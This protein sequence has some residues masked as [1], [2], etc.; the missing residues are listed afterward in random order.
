MIGRAQRDG[1][2]ALS[3]DTGTV[4]K[5]DIA[6]WKNINPNAGDIFY[7]LLD[8]G[9]LHGRSWNITN[10]NGDSIYLHPSS[11]Y[12]NDFKLNHDGHP[13]IYDR[14]DSVFDVFD[15]SYG[16][17][18]K[19][20]TQDHVTD[21]HELQLFTDHYYLIGYDP[22]VI[23]MKQYNPNYSSNAFVLGTV[24]QEFDSG[25]HLI[26]DWDSFDHVEVIEA[27]HEQ[28]GAQYIDY[29]HTNSIEEDTDGNIIVS[30]R[31][32]DQITKIDT[33]TGDFIWRL[34]GIM[35]QFT[36]INDS[37]HFTYQHDVR[38]LPNGDITVFD[39]GDF[40]PVLVSTAK[41]YALDL[42][43]MTATLVWSYQ[44]PLIQGKPLYAHAMGSIQRFENG[45]TFIDWGWV[46]KGDSIPSMTEIDANK[47]IVWEA[48]VTPE[49]FNVIYRAH[50]YNWEPC[51]RVSA[52]TMH[53]INIKQDSAT[54]EWGNA[55][56]GKSYLIQYA[57]TADDVWKSIYPNASSDTFAVLTG[58]QP[59]HV[60]EWQMQ[61]FCSSPDPASSH[62]TA[63]QK[64]TTLSITSA[65]DIKN[66]QLDLF[67]NPAAHSVIISLP[68]FSST[69]EVFVMNELGSEVL[70]T[71]AHPE[72]GKIS[73]AV[74]LLSSG[75]YFIKIISGEKTFTGKLLIQK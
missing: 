27:L 34:G 32:L 62:F 53:T 46:S 24:V 61:T 69:C 38:R 9:S 60:Y 7:D 35:N 21:N 29:M 75:I 1:E 52:T 28:L 11:Y 18:K 23:N 6:I 42:S 25:G 2:D 37:L 26:F 48:K 14:Y 57:N 39:N 50:R 12:I 22:E 20:K 54:I 17:I 40:H 13:T 4:T 51:A 66:N 36:F 33:K 43:N 55:T 3:V 70:R 68:V 19:L 73:L 64:F 41:E 45:G 56:N 10:S 44:H 67:P 31:H 16:V 71:S 58:L 15:S 65:S 63:I 30:H 47:Q 74:D 59:G 5:M 8:G 49:A 72:D